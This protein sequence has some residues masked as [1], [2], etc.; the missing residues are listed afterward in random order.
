MIIF[1]NKRASTA[2]ASKKKL[3]GM[4]DFI[5]HLKGIPNGDEDDSPN[6]NEVAT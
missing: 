2:S 5:N 1:L 3:A 4:A 6:A